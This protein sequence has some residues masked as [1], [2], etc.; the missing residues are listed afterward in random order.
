[1]RFLLRINAGSLFGRPR[2]KILFLCRFLPRV[3][4]SRPHRRRAAAC[5]LTLCPV[6]GTLCVESAY[7]PRLPSLAR[8][9]PGGLLPFLHFH[10]IIPVKALLVNKLKTVNSCAGRGPPLSVPAHL[11]R[12]LRDCPQTFRLPMLCIMCPPGFVVALL[13]LC[14]LSIPSRSLWHTRVCYLRVSR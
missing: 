12:P 13:F 14:P 3:P 8:R 1:M 11:R 7:F 6:Y 2:N 10:I 9:S 5:R 4:S